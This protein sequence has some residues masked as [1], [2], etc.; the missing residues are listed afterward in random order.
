[1]IRDLVLLATGFALVVL[2]SALGTVLGLGL[3]MP[4]PALP[5]VIYLGMAPDVALARGAVLSFL[6]GWLVDSACG[7]A[8][9]LYTFV[10]VA[11]FLVARGAGFRLIMRGRISQ[12]LITA[13]ASVVGAVTL[14][15]LRSIFRP[16]VRFETIS[17]QHMVAAVLAPGLSTGAIAPFVFQ[18]ARR[19]DTF[20]RREEGAAIT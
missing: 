3:L 1:V 15:A 17:P 20:R 4:N 19:I 12:V 5:M 14:I 10:H 7:N 16:E 8:M 9:G 18:L 2:Q 13:L 11:T 6:L